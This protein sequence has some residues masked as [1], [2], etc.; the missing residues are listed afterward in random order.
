MEIMLKLHMSAAHPEVVHDMFDKGKGYMYTCS[1]C[2]SKYNMKIMLK[3]HMLAAHP[4]VAHDVF[5][6]DLCHKI[7]RTFQFQ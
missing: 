3:L 1:T 5:D 4:E 7:S 2:N 6:K